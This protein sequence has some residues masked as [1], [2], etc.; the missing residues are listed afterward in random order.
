MLFRDRIYAVRD[1]MRT[2]GWDAVIIPESLVSWL[3]GFT[4][5]GEMVI[6]QDHAGLWTDSR[7]F[8]QADQQL[9]GTGVE[10]H[11]RPVLDVV[12]I[13]HRNLSR[14]RHCGGWAG[15]KL[16]FGR[17]P[18]RSPAGRRSRRRGRLPH[19]QRP[20]MDK[21]HLAGPAGHSARSG[22]AAGNGL[23]RL[24]PRAEAIL[25]S[26]AIGCKR[27]RCHPAYRPG[28]SGVDAECTGQRCALCPRC[29]FV[30]D[31]YPERGPLV[32]AERGHAGRRAG[33]PAT[34]RHRN[35]GL[36]R[37]R[38]GP[39]GRPVRPGRPFALVRSRHLELRPLRRLDDP[40]AGR[41][42]PGRPLAGNP[43]QGRQERSGDSRDEKSPP[44]GRTG[45]GKILLLAGAIPGG[46]HG[47]HRMGGCRKTGGNPP[48]RN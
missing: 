26:W 30:S 44:G 28:R 39:R 24:D 34:R 40:L 46:R 31:R 45:P 27:L 23:Y 3:S 13:P 25:A 6:T 35:F 18:P 20:G 9:A 48:R 42:C 21:R 1:L 11:K 43:A 19:R 16:C 47:H 4:G 32:C 17:C 29:P 14:H 7:Y 15:A 5:E 36:R 10:M 2:H 22:D 41:R 8:I 37:C 33:P 38:P 12:S